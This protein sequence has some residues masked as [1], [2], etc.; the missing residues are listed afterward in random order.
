MFEMIAPIS[1][2]KQCQERSRRIFNGFLLWK[3]LK[4]SRIGEIQPH[5]AEIRVKTGELYINYKAFLKQ[6]SLYVIILTY[7]EIKLFT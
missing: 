6:I 7:I 1:I 5:E 2:N 3:K 4:D